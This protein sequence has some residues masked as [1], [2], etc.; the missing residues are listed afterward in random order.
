MTIQIFPPNDNSRFVLFKYNPG[1]QEGELLVRELRSNPDFRFIRG[2]P[3]GI[4]KAEILARD[5]DQAIRNLQISESTINQ[6]VAER[7]QALQ[8]TGIEPTQKEQQLAASLPRS[9]RIAGPT[10]REIQT[11]ASLQKG[12]RDIPPGQPEVSAEFEPNVQLT[13]GEQAFATPPRI[14][15]EQVPQTIDQEI[16]QRARV[17]LARQKALGEA[18]PFKQLREAIREP[19]PN[20]SPLGQF[21]L[22]A[23]RG[24]LT[25]PEAILTT[26]SITVPSFFEGLIQ[27]SQQAT[28]AVIRGAEVSY[29]QAV[30][31]I[32][33]RPATAL[34]E[35]AAFFAPL[36]L[37]KIRIPRIELPEISLP[38]IILRSKG[39]EVKGVSTK[40][41][42]FFDDITIKLDK[43]IT[44][45]TTIEPQGFTKSRIQGSIFEAEAKVAKGFQVKDNFF[46]QQLNFGI[47]KQGKII[48]TDSG[49]L[50][51]QFTKVDAQLRKFSQNV[52]T[53][54]M[55]RL[56]M[57]AETFKARQ[58]G[59][60]L[61]TGEA[62]KFNRPPKGTGGGGSQLKFRQPRLRQRDTTQTFKEIEKRLEKNIK[63]S[64]ARQATAMEFDAISR[65]LQKQLGQ[66]T[67]ASLELSI[68]KKARVITTIRA[69]PQEGNIDKR[70]AQRFKSLSATMAATMQSQ[71]SKAAQ[72]S[73][74]KSREGLKEGSLLRF[75][76]SV[77]PVQTQRLNFAQIEQQIQKQLQRQDTTTKTPQLTKQRITF[78]PP[79]RLR[80]SFFPTSQEQI[81]RKMPR[82]KMRRQRSRFIYEPSLI[83]IS[84]QIRR[85]KRKLFSGLEVR[86]V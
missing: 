53:V 8:S 27:D 6:F 61:K 86:G 37:A 30:K 23:G 54:I 11:K 41:Q 50:A 33:E 74:T 45:K 73:G 26:A 71:F 65:E 85:D 16:S 28:Q 19:G 40:T 76:Q 52:D 35:A 64:Q 14:I 32:T 21:L 66:R 44:F 63:G 17:I 69:K 60:N 2:A 9:I 79:T 12:T 49:P 10:A 72:V 43:E 68:P 42:K 67:P 48:K 75:R 38:K 78:E 39:Q 31:T 83:G 82:A 47:E 13:T 80:R 25:T 77:K 59:F 24:I 4:I 84:R 34:G 22:T 51:L 5:Q 36:A 57:R 62:P 70:L 58:P 15:T 56:N 81:I 55:R 3:G 18:P 20:E 1:T 29:E 46:T 7:Q